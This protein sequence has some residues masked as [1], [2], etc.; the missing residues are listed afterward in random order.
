MKR[1]EWISTGCLVGV[2]S[3]IFVGWLS[4]RSRPLPKDSVAMPEAPVAA[5]AAPQA[6]AAADTASE[7][8]AETA[9]KEA[10]ANQD[11]RRQDAEQ[12]DEQQPETDRPRPR[13]EQPGGEEGG[14]PT[15]ERFDRP[16]GDM[17]FGSRRSGRSRFGS[18]QPGEGRSR[19]SDD[20]NESGLEAI[21]LNDVE[22]KSIVQKLGEWTG[23]PVIPVSDEVMQT[24]ITI[25]SSE[26]VTRAR[27][28]GLLIA[29]LHARGVM[30]DQTGDM[31]LLKPLASARTGS[32][33][34]LSVDDPLARIQEPT[35]IVEKW[36]Q[37]SSYSP[38]QLAQVVGGLI[39]DYGYVAADETTGRVS[40]IETVENLRRIERV[41]E[42]LDVPE[43]SLAVEKI[44]EL[45]VADPVEVVQVLQLILEDS[46]TSG[47]SRGSADRFRGR[48]AERG[49]ASAAAPSVV[50]AAGET[51]VRLIPVP[52][53]RWILAR[54]SRADMA[55]I[56]EW[57][58]KLD[59][60]E[61][62]ESRQQVIPVRYANVT[63]VVR[64]VNNTIQQ[65][66]GTDLK[67]NVVVEGLAQSNQIVVF[68]SEENLKLV[69]RLIAEIDLPTLDIF[70]EKTFILKYADP[71]QIKENIDNLY[72]DAAAA[73]NYSANYYRYG[74]GANTSEED[75]VKAISYP[76]FK[77]V[78]VIASE[79]N[80]DK[81]TKLITEE[82]DIPMDIKSDQY[83][84]L[85]LENSDPVQMAELLSKLFSEE[86]D[87]SGTSQLIWLLGGS[88]STKKK[89]VGSLYGMLT[90]EPVPDTKRIIVISKI[91]EAYDV[92]EELVKK[93]DGQEKAEVPRVLTLKYADPEDLCEQLNA[94]MNEPGTTATI[95]RSVRGLG[96]YDMSTGTATA[97]T[98]A[99]ESGGQ[100]DSTI[101]TWWSGQRQA[102]DEMPTSNLIGR[103][104]FVPVQRSKAILVLS[105]PEYIADI[106]Q[107]VQNL[108]QPGMQVM[109]K[110]VVM[111][112]NHSD[113][114]SLGV[115]FSS[116]PTAFGQFGINSIDILN[117]IST[118]VERGSFS[119]A[120][121]SN[122]DALIDLLVKEANARVLNQPTLW[123][124]DNEEAIFIK[125]R[126]VAFITSDSFDR[127]NTDSVQRQ[128]EFENVGVI[129]RVR[130]NITP[131][132][133]VN[134]T[135]HLNVSQLESEIVNT[136]PVRRN[137]DT[138]THLIVNDG[139]SIIM[140]G[141]LF[142]NDDERIQKVPLLGDLPLVGGLFRHTFTELTNDELIVFV[143]PYV[144]D[145][146]D[147]A[148]IPVDSNI[149]DVKLLEHPRGV[150]REELDV[151]QN[152]IYE[153]FFAPEPEE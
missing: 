10:P 101:Q 90:F 67:A 19:E 31:I 91:V 105:P 147:M 153:E 136:Q 146:M 134:M 6:E 120:A 38:T 54:A 75:T 106:E 25:Y 76:A 79:K 45:K 58:A 127:T 68:G 124:K 57:V 26:R 149:E 20:P 23:K 62:Q 99:S 70:K 71:D 74:P 34:T 8:A 103:V 84:I 63:E 48:G 81:I 117:E 132:K 122:V 37:L 47:L 21:Q 43:S 109:I 30:V 18:E 104:R 22:M 14:R 140:G 2:L 4:A 150:V 66:P 65:M 12:E 148:R 151:L 96:D 69:E 137:L 133:A 95:R 82:W 9:S 89:I 16:Q 52:K 80:L 53:Q 11:S 128:F 129:L 139:Q 85:T 144:I 24:K 152:K 87:S 59:L 97:A 15:F 64:M 131:E 118:S 116:D 61:A 88:D 35:Q 110:V 32:V 138:I 78:T 3:L 1:T 145:E 143:T 56:E 142:Q 114:T 126:K 39:S 102:E 55:R 49:R 107:M 113:M 51:P 73:S 17:S 83:R 86:Q 46:A 92:I 100:S 60:A 7:P 121:G 33:P 50:V 141:L 41:I 29:A 40:V 115:Q 93:L 94:I 28:L 135:V 36:F 27:A 108:D 77:R 42:Q 112:V 13:P 125:A 130:P 111:E 44:I 123:T 72:S 119:F 5:A 98:G